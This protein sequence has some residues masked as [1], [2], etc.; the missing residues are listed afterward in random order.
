MPEPAP[1][2]G[3]ALD[4]WLRL[5]ADVRA[6]EGPTAVLMALSVFLLLTAYYI[7]KP[8]REALI[9]AQGSA[10]LKSYL[11]AAMVVVLA[12]VIPVYGRLV[13]RVPRRR[14]LNIVTGFFAACLAVFY[15]LASFQV[16][17]GIVFFV[18]VGIFNLMV[19]AQFWGFA[20]DIYSQDQGERLF[21][22]VGFGASLGGVLG[23]V[24]ANWLI[25]PL[26]VYQLMLVGGA[27]LVVQAILT[28]YVDTKA[29]SGASAP[30]ASAARPVEDAG[31]GL[32]HGA[33]RLVFATPYL[34]MIALMI[35]G[36]NWVNTTGQYILDGVVKNAATAAVAAGMAGGLS[37]EA[38]IGEFF[39]RFF[40]VVNV[41]SLVIQLFLVSR[42]IKYFGVRVGI[43]ILPCIAMGAYSLLAFFP[44]LSA[45]RWAKTA[46]NST[47]YSLNNTV[48][49]MLFLTCTRE[50]KYTSKQV[51]DSFFQRAGDVLSA[52]LVFVGTT[53]FS[54][55]AG[56]FARVCLLIVVAW[57]ALAVSVGREYRRLVG[58]DIAPGPKL[59]SSR[60]AGTR[61][62][63][64]A[65]PG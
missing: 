42:I 37:V 20:N 2:P 46:E 62:R 4:R 43:M 19:I 22:I 27:L 64:A 9:L 28:S 29:R 25:A 38:Y 57:I 31:P 8:V 54:L 34:L 47:D 7:L 6:G 26:G 21:P 44:V 14:L 23:A 61:P 65:I 53:Y 11:S 59:L 30:T 33:F 15:G 3:R 16:P 49:N 39:S 35:L 60:A 17:L 32:S 55:S 51:I 56:G 1:S 50:Q 45:V 41:A 18:W 10:E 52:I 5:F 40:A 13:A 63:P 58:A 24:I 48:R 36:L 12:L